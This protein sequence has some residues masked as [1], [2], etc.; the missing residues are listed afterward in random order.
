MLVY[1]VVMRGYSPLN[2]FVDETIGVFESR[3]Q[4]EGICDAISDMWPEDRDGLVPDV[5]EHET[6]RIEA[7]DMAFALAERMCDA[8]IAGAESS[9]PLPA[10]VMDAVV[11]SHSLEGAAAREFRAAYR[12]FF[13]EEP[14][15]DETGD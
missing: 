10:D 5:I 11:G 2:E 15:G 6:G 4:A 7:T 1:E 8:L 9:D 3:N 14:D 12:P 13:E